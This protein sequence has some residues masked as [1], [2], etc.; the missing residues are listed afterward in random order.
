MRLGFMNPEIQLATVHASF[1]EKRDA[2]M[3]RSRI[4]EIAWE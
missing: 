1:S 4:E 2:L 3:I